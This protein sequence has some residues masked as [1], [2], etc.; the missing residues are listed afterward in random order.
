MKRSAEGPEGGVA[1]R[2]PS[3]RLLP[4]AACAAA[5]AQE[6]ATG[7]AKGTLPPF[8]GIRVKTF[9]REMHARGEIAPLIE[10]AF[11]AKR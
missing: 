5:T 2:S 7:I 3:P 4:G 9:S 6:V 11:A 1:S 10:Q 8:I